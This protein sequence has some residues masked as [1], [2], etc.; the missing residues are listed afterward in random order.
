MTVAH[1]RPTKVRDKLRHNFIYALHDD[2]QAHGVEA[3]Q[4]ARENDPLGYVKVI[5]SLM[6]KEVE[7]HARPLDELSDEQLSAALAAV[8]AI[9]AAANPGSGET[10]TRLQESTEVLQAIPET[11]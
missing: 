2:F 8:R 3:I 10:V 4:L 9:E 5:A 7:V 11:S 6:P 1:G